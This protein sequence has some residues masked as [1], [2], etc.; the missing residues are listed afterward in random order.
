MGVH[1]S[2]GI[3][4]ICR[5]EIRITIA[6]PIMPLGAEAIVNSHKMTSQRL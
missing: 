5:Q 4:V 2:E 3:P 6:T 1:N